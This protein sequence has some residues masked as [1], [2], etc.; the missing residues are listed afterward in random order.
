[1]ETFVESGWTTS[2]ERGWWDTESPPHNID[3]VPRHAACI[4]H[5]Q[6]HRDRLPGSQDAPKHY[7]YDGGG[8]VW[9]ILWSTYGLWC[10]GLQTLPQNPVGTWSGT[11]VPPSPLLLLGPTRYGC[12][13]QEIL[14]NIFQG[15]SWGDVWGGVLSPTVSKLVADAVI[16]HWVT[17]RVWT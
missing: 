4:S 1:M 17:V 6:N 10:P 16:R 13:D 14:C 8:S 9:N 15:L 2:F 11:S 5:R 12:T 7:G 3:L